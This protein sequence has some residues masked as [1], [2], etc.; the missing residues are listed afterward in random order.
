MSKDILVTIDGQELKATE[1]EFI[2]NI[3]RA[4][5]IFIPAICYLTRCSPT[6]ACRLC[7]VDIDGKRAYSC[8]AKAKDGMSITTLNDEIQQE[9]RAIMEVYDINHPLQCGVCDQSGECELQ[10]Y[11]LEMEVET[12]HQAIPDVLRNTKDWGHLKYDAGLCIV[13]ERCVS[14]CKDM[15]GDS[16]LKTVKRNGP[17]LDSEYKTTMPKD[18]YAIWN[19]MNKNLIGAV[20]GDMLDCTAC[21]ECSAVCPVGALVSTDFQ[22]KSNAWELESIPA[23]CSHCSSGCH[24]YYE[25]KHTSIENPEEKIYRVRN[26]F[27]YKSLCGAGRYGYDFENKNVIKDEDKF[28]KTIEAFK[29]ADTINFSSYIT[30]EEAFIL[31]KLKDKFNY[32]LVNDDA[33]KFKNFLDNYSKISGKSFYS[34]NLKDIHN[35]NFV[36]SIGSMLKNDLPNVRYA[37]NNALTMN[38]GAGLYFH[39][40]ADPVVEGFSKNLKTIYHSP[41]QEITILYLLLELFSDKDKLPLNIKEYLD[42]LREK[43][44]KTITETVKEK[45]V[46]KTVDADGNEK[47]V[48]KLVPKKVKKDIEIEFSTLLEK[49]GLDDSFY[50][51]LE[52]FLAKKTIFSLIVGEDCITSE[53]ANKIA[54]LVALFEKTSNFKILIIPSKTNTLGVGL[55]CD[56]DE[57]SGKYSIGYNQKGNFTLSGLGDGDLDIPALNQQEGTFTTIDKRVLP[58]NV[59]I[60]YNGYTLFDIAKELGVVTDKNYT[61]DYTID[62]PTKKGF[63]SIQFDELGIDFSNDISDNRGYLLENNNI[64]LANTSYDIINDYK[65]LDGVIVYRSNPVSQFSPFTNKAHQFS[66]VASLFVTD[67]FLEVNNLAEGDNVEISNGNGKLIL[68]LK[69][70]TKISGII[71]YVPTYDKSIDVDK[72]FGNGYRFAQ[73]TLKKV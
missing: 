48:T 60:S 63:K 41:N 3:A 23:T 29:K 15:I 19:K 4:N 16:A 24:I 18:S 25:K 68:P 40:I 38:K 34:A 67:K 72:I 46:T 13:C 32:K 21:G 31:Q 20:A 50:D 42:S 47:E 49:I 1:G 12:Q 45:V 10:N 44:V 30:N 22:Y 9:R 55:I 64:T 7:L 65:N 33:F 28:K 2:L 54:E 62:L 61:I 17:A 69:I 66:E 37:L 71:A 5:G 56:L 51:I 70:D 43:K 53:N 11:T 26:E 58:T 8:N 73:V 52:K 57:K 35:S 14:V 36:I 39:P 6:L 27:H 59:A